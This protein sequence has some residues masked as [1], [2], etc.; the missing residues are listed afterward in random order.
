M[1]APSLDLPKL[2]NNRKPHK[3]HKSKILIG[4]NLNKYY[5]NVVVY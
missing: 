1:N 3:T 2:F 5:K 4:S